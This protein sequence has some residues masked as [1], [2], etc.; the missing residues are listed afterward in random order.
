MVSGNVELRDPWE[1]R[2]Q[3]GNALHKREPAYQHCGEVPVARIDASGVDQHPKAFPSCQVLS[4]ERR[5]SVAAI[6][7]LPKEKSAC[8][9]FGTMYTRVMEPAGRKCRQPSQGL[10]ASAGT[11]ENQVIVCIWKSVFCL[12]EHYPL[13]VSPNCM[14]KCDHLVWAGL[15]VPISITTSPRLPLRNS[16]WETL[17]GLPWGTWHF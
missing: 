17:I 15:P 10:A 2:N 8:A 3:R 12:C 16:R 1:R 5:E 4:K 7:S 14:W 9:G 13:F 11:S 6:F